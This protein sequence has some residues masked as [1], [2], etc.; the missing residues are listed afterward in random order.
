M[1]NVNGATIVPPTLLPSEF[2]LARRQAA[3][4]F[5]R[6]RSPSRRRQA[7]NDRHPSGEAERAREERRQA[8]AAEAVNTNPNEPAVH[9]RLPSYLVVEQWADDDDEE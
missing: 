4:T 3:D 6:R 8:R 7:R 2:R 5:N 9:A 1:G